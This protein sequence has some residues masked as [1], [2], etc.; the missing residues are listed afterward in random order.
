MPEKE[1]GLTQFF[2][3]SIG[4]A[5]DR[6]RRNKSMEGL[7]VRHHLNMPTATVVPCSAQCGEIEDVHQ[8]TCALS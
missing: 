1:A 6:R 2:A 8:Q 4:I 7:Q 5:V 3:R